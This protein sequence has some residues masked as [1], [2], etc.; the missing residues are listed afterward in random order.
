MVGAELQIMVESHT[1]FQ[2]LL[3]CN[4]RGRIMEQGK[5][6]NPKNPNQAV[7]NQTHLDQRR[8]LNLGDTNRSNL[9]PRN[10]SLHKPNRTEHL[11]PNINNVAEKVGVFPIQS[12]E[13]HTDHDCKIE[14]TGATECVSGSTC[15]MI[16]EW[17]FQCV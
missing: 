15:Q 1:R 9:N 5:Q 10:L 11:Y 6:I 17:Y 8:N 4:A 3:C 13:S 2:A 16:N 12:R 14:H 7:L